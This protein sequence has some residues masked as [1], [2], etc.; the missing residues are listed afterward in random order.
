MSVATTTSEAEVVLTRRDYQLAVGWGLLS[1]LAAAA[2]AYAVVPAGLIVA[3]I[4]I[5]GVLGFAGYV[6]A[7]TKTI[8]DPITGTALAVALV[9]AI[10]F[11]ILRGW[12]EPVLITSALTAI[13][14]FGIMILLVFITGFA[15]GGDIKFSPAPAALLAILSPL[16]AVIWL[17][18]A[19][20]LTLAALSV[21]MLRNPADKTGFPMA[22]LMAAAF[23][24]ALIIHHG[25]FG[26]T[27]A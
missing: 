9:G 24:L 7:R 22:P 5:A 4:A 12:G 20:L 27:A 3:T 26:S 2:I 18:V 21:R 15:S 13:G 17:G 25:I 14:I 16:T 19:F 10:A 8:P 1:A 6:D 11:Q 23:P